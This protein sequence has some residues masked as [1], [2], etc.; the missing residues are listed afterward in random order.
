[1]AG[2]ILR[3]P[4]PDRRRPT[5][6]EALL[7]PDQA[8]FRDADS[9]WLWTSTAC[10]RQAFYGLPAIRSALLGGLSRECFRHL[11]EEM[12][13]VHRELASLFAAM[14]GPGWVDT[15]RIRGAADGIARDL[16]CLETD[17]VALGRPTASAP[18]SAAG[19]TT[20]LLLS[21]FRQ[22]AEVA[23]SHGLAT[24]LTVCRATLSALSRRLV[25]ATQVRWQT[26]DDG[27]FGYWLALDVAYR[28]GLVLP[29]RTEVAQY[30]AGACRMRMATLAQTKLIYAVM[31][32]AFSHALAFE[33]LEGGRIIFGR[34]RMK[35]DPGEW[36][37]LRP[38]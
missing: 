10:H 11:L 36:P 8:T 20:A 5:M 17:L 21:T 31:G 16:A 30:P 3:M 2:Q 29:P 19:D 35:A 14:R 9:A 13:A 24:T 34:K 15:R 6:V 37:A 12:A 4:R 23:G 28:D 7:V 1:M 33:E 22:T 18:E 27:G 25:L 26:C 38:G 32:R